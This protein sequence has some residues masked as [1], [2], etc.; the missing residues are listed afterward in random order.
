[1]PARHRA[2]IALLLVST[3]PGGAMPGR[4]QDAA[5]K[6]REWKLS[7]AVGPAFALGKAAELWAKRAAERSGGTLAIATHPGASLALRDPEREFAALRDGAAD[8]AVGSTLHWSAQVDALAVVGLPWLAPD[9]RALATLT[10]GAAR[11]AMS[12]AIERAGA[13]PLAFAPLGHRALATRTAPVRVPDDVRGLRVRIAPSPYLVDLYASLGA[14]PQAMAFTD[15]AAAFRSGGLD[16]QEG[17]PAAFVAARLDTLGLRHVTLWGAVAEIA[18][19]AANRA[20]WDGWTTEQ[21]AAVSDAAREAAAGLRDLASQE[22]LA[23]LATLKSREVG[24]LQPTAS[25]TAA[26]AAAARP[27]YGKWAAIAG[28]EVVRAA[29]AAVAAKP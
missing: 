28:A 6:P 27:V 21:R 25:G 20:V 17:P 29:E 8:L 1:M 13:V 23:A 19:F 4:A 11:D 2:L 5:P 3:L 9:A 12:A 18:V 16:A 14:L 10:T 24:L 22:A 26:F 7:V 15:A